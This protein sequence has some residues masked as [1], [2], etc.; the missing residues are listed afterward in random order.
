MNYDKSKIEELFYQLEFANIKEKQSIIQEISIQIP[1]ELSPL[2][3]IDQL[4]DPSLRI[5]TR[6]LIPAIKLSQVIHYLKNLV[7]TTNYSNYEELEQ[8]VFLISSIVDVHSSYKDFKSKL[9]AI[10]F[11]VKEL[12]ELNKTIL[13][14]NT[15]IILL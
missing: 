3:I 7:N 10:S 12:Y 1:W 13:N 9:D 4:S 14:D 11:R 2:E 8:G 15:K 5:Y 6:A